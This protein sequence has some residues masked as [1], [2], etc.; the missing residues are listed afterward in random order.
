MESQS[1]QTARVLLQAGGAAVVGQCPIFEF[2][3][4]YDAA[5]GGLPSQA[6]VDTDGDIFFYFLNETMIY[7]SS[8][9]I[10]PTPGEI[11]ILN[12]ARLLRSKAPV[13]YTPL[14]RQN[15]FWLSYL[16]GRSSCPLQGVYNSSIPRPRISRCSSEYIGAVSAS[17]SHITLLQLIGA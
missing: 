12:Q 6:R 7:H 10:A 2:W 13:G 11:G 5:V 16:L 15:I 4:G 14:D 8:L 3:R 9:S 1:V 17:P